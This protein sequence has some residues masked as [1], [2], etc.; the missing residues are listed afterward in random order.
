VSPGIPSSPE[1]AYV[2]LRTRSGTPSVREGGVGG[3]LTPAR[4]T[5]PERAAA[6]TAAVRL[7]TPSFE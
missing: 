1:S 3:Y 5:R 4:A 7:L 6:V 2:V